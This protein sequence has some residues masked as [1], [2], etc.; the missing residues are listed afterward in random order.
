MQTEVAVY[1]SCYVV[2]L[3]GEFNLALSTRTPFK[4]HS[5]PIR[6]KYMA[7]CMSQKF[8]SSKLLGRS[9]GNQKVPGTLKV[10]NSKLK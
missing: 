5:S 7:L 1:I 3:V 10:Q 9:H 6:A 4:A 8:G 2:E